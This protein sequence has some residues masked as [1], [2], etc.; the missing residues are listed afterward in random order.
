SFVLLM[1]VKWYLRD[2]VKI[3]NEEATGS[4]SREAIEVE[5][6]IEP[7]KPVVTSDVIR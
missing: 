4:K 1:V 2:Y 6:Q 3:Q 5:K 7:L